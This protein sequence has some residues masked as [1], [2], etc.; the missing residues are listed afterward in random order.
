[1]VLRIS[2]T[3]AIV[4]MPLV[5]LMAC[6]TGPTGAVASVGGQPSRAG[7]SQQTAI[8]IGNGH[9]EMTGVGAEYDWIEKNRPG[10]RPASQALIEDGG[11]YYDVITI[12]KEGKTQDIWFDITG[13]FG[14]L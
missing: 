10:W 12:T 9:N 5:C 13:F 14:V 11:H 6:Q 4:A 1:M 2:K 8:V 7:T 3:L